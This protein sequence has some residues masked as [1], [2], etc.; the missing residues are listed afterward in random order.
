MANLVW[1]IHFVATL[2][3]PLK[4]SY[5]ICIYSL[6]SDANYKIMIANKATFTGIL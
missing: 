2:D 4:A 5:T 3:Y 1:H 6:M